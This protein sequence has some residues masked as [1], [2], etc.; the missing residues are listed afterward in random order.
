MDDF[1]RAAILEEQDR[2][3]ALSLAL[4]PIDDGFRRFD[5]TC[6]DCDDPI[7]VDRLA[8]NP[9]AK[10]CEFCQSEAEQK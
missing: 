5:G 10:R 3:R 8:A 9:N 6:I 2:E 4:K 1:D 7:E